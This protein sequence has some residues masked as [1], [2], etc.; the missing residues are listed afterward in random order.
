MSQY[1][2]SRNIVNNYSCDTPGLTIL[3]IFLRLSLK[4]I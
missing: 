2:K 1:L 4:I 3:F